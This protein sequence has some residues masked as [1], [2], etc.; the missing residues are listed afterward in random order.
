MKEKESILNGLRDLPKH[1]NSKTI[2]SGIISGIFGWCTA[3]ILYAN[4][5]ACGWSAQETVSWIFACWVFGPILGIIISLKYKKPIPGAWSISGA[6]IVVSG[7]AAGYSLQQMCAGFLIAGILVFIL[8]IIGLINKVMKYLPMPI[9]MGMTA[10]C[11]FKFVTNIVNYFYTW[12][13]DISNP[14]NT[15]YFIIAILAVVTWLV[16]SKLKAKIKVIPPIL[17]ALVVVIICVFTFGLYDPSAL[18]GLTFYGP[19]FIGFSFEN[20]LGVIV[21]VS[22]PLT[23]LVI[24]AENAQAIG[25]LKSQGYVPPV[26]AMTVWSGI[27]GMVTSL[28]GGH[29]AN[30]AGPMTAIVASDES[31]KNKDDRYASAVVCGLFCSIIG[32]FSSILVPFLNTMPIKL[33]Y[34][35][36]GLAMIGVILSSLQ[37]AFKVGKFQMSAFFA[38]FVALAQKSFLGIGS[39]FW[40]LL[41]GVVVAGILET[42]DFKDVINETK[43]V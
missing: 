32:V 7:A 39:A 8:G 30:I 35:I 10:G 21:S 4:G 23:F 14:N 22:L 36:A 11:L 31:G 42:K 17:A 1:L 2:S 18:A 5:N 34:L 38:F 6:A 43:G 20:I 40:A 12:S 25:V 24:G 26:K 37:S 28:F 16:F 15:K 3:L 29:N 33:I 13:T 41:I 27:G 9:V 19:K